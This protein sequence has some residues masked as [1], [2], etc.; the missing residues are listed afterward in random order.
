[1]TDTDPRSHILSHY[2]DRLPEATERLC[3]TCSVWIVT[4]GYLDGKVRSYCR[5]NCLPIQ[6]DGTDCPYYKKRSEG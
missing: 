1:M 4:K 3:G 6:S 5:E 2:G